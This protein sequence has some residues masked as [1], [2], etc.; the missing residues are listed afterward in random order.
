[1]DLQIVKIADQ[2]ISLTKTEASIL[3]L[4]MQNPTQVITK[5]QLIER[6]NQET[7][8]CTESSLKVHVSNLRK[9]LRVISDKDYIESVWGIGFKMRQEES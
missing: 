5:S 3:R 1:M 2:Q 9:K 6:I 8:Y 4:L 7:Y